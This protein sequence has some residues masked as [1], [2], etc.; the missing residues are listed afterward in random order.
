LQV[1]LVKKSRLDDSYII[2]YNV[3]N[4][5]LDKI[6]TT[7]VFAATL[8]PYY[9]YPFN[10][11]I[12][13]SL[14]FA[15]SNMHSQKAEQSHYFFYQTDIW[16]S[17]NAKIDEIQIHNTQAVLPL[18]LLFRWK[19]GLQDREFHKGPIIDNI[20]F[21]FIALST[22]QFLFYIRDDRQLTIWQYDYPE[23][24]ERLEENAWQELI[25]YSRDSIGEYHLPQPSYWYH[26]PE[27]K[28]H[29][30]GKHHCYLAIQDTAFFQ[31][32]FKIVQ[33]G[34]EAFCI[35]RDTGYIYHIGDEDITRVGEIELKNYPRWLLGKPLFIEDRDAGRLVFLSD[36]KRTN[37]TR[38][39]P[40]VMVLKSR[41][42]VNV[43]YLGL[44]GRR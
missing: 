20:T 14:I 13:D 32:H 6:D 25:T 27:L 41:S 1:P 31:G 33:Q 17:A 11:D 34:S 15:V 16:N 35:N 42:A 12:T 24:G 23:Y 3:K 4:D 37:E 19:T 21:D 2:S 38:P 5:Q 43:Q 44:R 10:W 26:S 8:S 30:S 40:E 7:N 28:Y 29:P 22:R 39:F 36:V 9:E 18:T